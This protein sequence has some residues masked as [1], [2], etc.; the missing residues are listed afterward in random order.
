MTPTEELVDRLGIEA[1]HFSG[2]R[3]YVRAQLGDSDVRLTLAV[4][5]GSYGIGVFARSSEGKDLVYDSSRALGSMGLT[6][7]IP[8]ERREGSRP[9]PP[10]EFYKDFPVNEISDEQLIEFVSQLEE[11]FGATAKRTRES[12][13]V[14]RG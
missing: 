1:T 11:L 12:A 14:L 3:R 7:R 2:N 8:R 10:V 9:D 4:R 5:R 13:L 6:E